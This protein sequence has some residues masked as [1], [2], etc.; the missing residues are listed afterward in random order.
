MLNSLC[1]GAYAGICLG[2]GRGTIVF[3]LSEWFYSP[4]VCFYNETSLETI[5]YSVIW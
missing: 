1:S 5:I 4:D 3:L 2:G